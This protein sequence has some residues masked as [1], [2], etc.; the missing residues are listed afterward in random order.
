MLEKLI[1]TKQA[2]LL[3]SELIAERLEAKKASRFKKMNK[4]DILRLANRFESIGLSKSEA[5]K[6][7]YFVD[8]N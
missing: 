5:L 1:A 7:A 3:A 8:R 6:L 2:R 4:S